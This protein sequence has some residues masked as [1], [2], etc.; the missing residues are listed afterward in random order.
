MAGL[1]SLLKG[2]ELAHRYRVE[3]VIGR[4]GMGAVYRATDA[5]LGRP[6]AVK[7]ITAAVGNDPEVRERL[8]ARFRHE[9]ASAA[10]LPHHPNVVPVYDYGTDEALGLDFLVMELLRGEDLA[11]R[12]QKSG[13]P[14]LAEALRIL[15]HAARGVA[16]GHR[17]GLIHRD[18]KPGN[19]FLVRQGDDEE[20]RV[21]D[22]GIAKAVADEDTHTALTQD[23]RAPLSPAYA[24][25]EQLRGES[26]LTPAS[27]VFSL[28]AIG[29]QLLAGTR[30]FTEADR[31]RMAAGLEVPAPSLRSRNP[32]LPDEVERI[33]RRALAPEPGGR[34]AD[35]G[36]L[37]D[38]LEEPLRR[39]GETPAAAA[40]AAIAVAPPPPRDDDRTVLAA[41]PEDDDRTMLAPPPPVYR[42]PVGAVIP[43]G[44]RRHVEE[45]RG[46]PVIVWILLFLAIGAA[47][48]VGWQ[49]MVER[50]PGAV[51]VDPADTLPD[52]DPLTAEML[53]LEGLRHFRAE[54]YD[55]ALAYFNR[56]VALEPRVPTYRDQ[57]AATLIR[58][59]QFDEAASLLRQAIRHVDPRFDLFHSRLAEAELALGDTVSAI[60]ALERF[61]ELT[62]DGQE[63]RRAMRLL[64]NLREETAAP[65]RPVPE[66]LDTRPWVPGPADEAEEPVR[67]GPPDTIRIGPP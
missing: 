11:S 26:R 41:P 45:R 5:R 63:R 10:S 16:V 56:A 55:S 24:S 14:P 2:R 32:H 31:N 22:F 15:Q 51:A 35:A 3:E 28:G 6:V 47:A 46:V 48:F 37:A 25:P 50:G 66:P 30:P 21:L 18:V 57:A 43:P 49:Q 52:E 23:G 58:M 61:V 67:P 9:A 36:A 54:Q 7:V 13:P 12:L 44:R 62:A 60:A 8:R 29:F 42:E 34:Y 17:A 27:D 33:V 59:G 38:A 19:V 1:E 39:V 53:S 20:V 4:G 64:Q 40:S 65:I